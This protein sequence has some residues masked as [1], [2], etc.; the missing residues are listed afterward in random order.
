MYTTTHDLKVETIRLCM[1]IF[2]ALT[3]IIY[4]LLTVPTAYLG[5]NPMHVTRHGEKCYFL[6]S[7]IDDT[8]PKSHSD[9]F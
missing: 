6:L 9:N 3:V 2:G 8:V 5:V 7:V 1:H 4:L